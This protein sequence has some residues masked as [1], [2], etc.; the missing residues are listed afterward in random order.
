MER[1]VFMS[2][3]YGKDLQ[4]FAVERQRLLFQM[5]E[6]INK[7]RKNGLNYVEINLGKNSDLQFLKSLFP[8]CSNDCVT[9]HLNSK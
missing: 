3:L 8:S 9:I 4:K 2:A 6:L 7:A 5:F 1:L